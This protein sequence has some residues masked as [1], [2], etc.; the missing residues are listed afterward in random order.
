MILRQELGQDI[1]GACGQ[2]VVS[3]L[4]PSFRSPAAKPK[5]SDIEDLHPSSAVQGPGV[6]LAHGHSH[7]QSAVVHT[8]LNSDDA[9]APKNTKLS[10]A[11][12]KRDDCCQQEPTIVAGLASFAKSLSTAIFIGIQ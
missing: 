7:V 4:A 12:C 10:S 2:L 3:T 1:N 6:N 9:V 8:S 11:S 5:V